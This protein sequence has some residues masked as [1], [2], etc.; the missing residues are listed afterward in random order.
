MQVVAHAL[1]ASNS[2]N[3]QPWRIELHQT[4]AMSFCLFADGTRLTPQV[5]PYARQTTISEGTFL[6]YAVVAAQAL[7]YECI[8]KLFPKGE[9]NAQGTPASMEERPAAEVKLVPWADAQGSTEADS[10]LERTASGTVSAGSLYD[11]L[12]LPDTVRVAYEDTSLTE[13]QVSRLTNE[14]APVTAPAPGR[15]VT[16]FLL[17]GDEDRGRLGELA[18][19]GAMVEGAVGRI[20]EESGALFRSTEYQKNGWR[21]GFSLEGQGT[22]GFGRWL[23]QGLLAIAPSLA[24]TG[25]SNE[26][27]VD[28][29]IE[30]VQHTPAYVLILTSDNSRTSQV[31]AGMAYARMQLTA[32][33]MGLAVQ[34]ISQVLE[35]YP[36][37]K[38][39][40]D[41]VHAQY[42]PNGETIQMLVRVGVPTRDVPHSMRRDAADLLM[43]TA[44]SQ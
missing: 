31:A 19:D 14:A 2:H 42:A 39:L 7:G 4:D 22:S 18:V 15:S 32:Q 34:P 40:R 12:F 20:T 3:M 8:V 10:E 29:T 24:S 33:S 13:E 35:E 30:Q 11:C 25:D 37:M 23:M 26:R 9:Y 16:V 6:E 41:R 28:Q 44:P 1:L 27:F 38:T 17:Q 5:D 36:E 43:D 21:S